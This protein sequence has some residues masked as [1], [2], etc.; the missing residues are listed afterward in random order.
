MQ[1]LVLSHSECRDFVESWRG[2]DPAQRAEPLRVVGTEQGAGQVS[3]DWS[4]IGA[5]A[6][7]MD[8]E[9]AAD[10]SSDPDRTEGRCALLLHAALAG[11]DKSVLDD[12]GFWRYLA[13]R[14]FWKLV[15]WRQPAALGE[16]G[17]LITA[18]RYVDGRHPTECVPTRMY[19]R[20]AAVG[21]GADDNGTEHGEAAH[22][23]RQATD[24]W[25][26]HVLR[27]RTA[28]APALVRA[29]VKRQREQRL[30]TERLR[31]LAKAVNRTWSNVALD[32]YDEEEA[33]HLL[34]DL[35]DWV[36][37]GPAEPQGPRNR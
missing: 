36:A 14:Y 12:D 8:L 31:E 4:A 35:N 27:V 10:G 16:N 15:C 32:L 18:L 20:A 3:V 11:V 7:Q 25:R 6:R 26:S 30:G 24:F 23:L 9:I 33:A 28:T 5:A 37:A 13:L 34:D 17:S 19:L 2:P 1:Y 22:T 21:A 29:F